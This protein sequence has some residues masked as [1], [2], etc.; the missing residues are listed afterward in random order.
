M[1]MYCVQL[2]SSRAMRNYCLNVASHPLPPR[3]MCGASKDQNATKSNCC[4]NHMLHKRSCHYGIEYICSSLLLYTLLNAYHRRNGSLSRNLHCGVAV[5]NKPL[6][7]GRGLDL[8]LF[9]FRSHLFFRAAVTWLFA[10][11]CI[12]ALALLLGSH[13]YHLV[14]LVVAGYEVHVGVTRWEQFVSDKHYLHA[15]RQMED[16]F[17]FLSNWPMVNGH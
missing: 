16:K 14:K 15:N 4:L 5:N 12:D 9:D 3:C 13:C 2:L 10:L 1:C 17:S 11:N 6:P 7:V 8:L